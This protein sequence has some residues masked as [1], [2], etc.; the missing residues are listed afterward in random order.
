MKRTVA[1][2]GLV[3]IVIGLTAD[4]IGIGKYSGIG[5]IQIGLMVVGAVMVIGSFLMGGRS[6]DE[7]EE[8]SEETHEDKPEG[9]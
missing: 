3:I 6:A 7:S 9:N 4:V 1:A 5:A 8:T 2:V